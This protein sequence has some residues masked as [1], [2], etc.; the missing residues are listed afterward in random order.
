MDQDNANERE[1]TSP[2]P[3]ESWTDAEARLA[4]AQRGEKTPL[5][6]D[7]LLHEI[8]VHQIE[9]PNET[10]RQAQAAMEESG[11]RYVDLYDFAPVGYLTLSAEGLIT[12]V[13]LTGAA[14]L[15]DDREML[16]N[17]RFADFVVAADSERW[18]GQFRHVLKQG[19]KHVVELSL[20]HADGTAFPARLDCLQRK[21]GGPLV[22]RIA[23]WD[24]TE[25]KRA[26]QA[27][28]DSKILLQSVIDATP[29]WIYVKDSEHRF[30]LVNG[31]FAKAFSRAPADMIG[32]HDTDFMPRQLCEGNPDDGTPGLHDSDSAVFAGQSLHVPCEVIPLEEGETRIFDT[33]KGPLRDTSQRIYGSLCYRRDITERFNKAQE[34]KALELQL[35]QAQKMELVGQLTGG[36]AHDFNNILASILGYAELVQMSPDIQQNSRLTQYLREILQAG[37]RAKEL[38]T[39]LLTFSGRREVPTEAINVA[40]IVKEVAKLLRSTLPTSIS[41]KTDI[42]RNLPQ[43]LMSP[44]QLHQVLMNLGINARDAIT[45]KGA[46]EVKAK[47]VALEGSMACDSCH[48]DFAGSHLVLS[49]RDTGSGIP[50]ENR[51]KIFHPFFTT[52]GVGLGSGLGLSVLHGIVHSANGH[53]KV[54]TALGEGTEFHVYLPPQS[55]DVAPFSREVKPAAGQIPVGRHVMLIDD[56][57]SI[58]GFMTPLLEN[59][60]C[61]VTGLTS[62]TVALRVFQ[63]DPNCVDM[64]I[65]DQTMPDLTGADLARAMLA[66]RR[67]IPVVVSTGYSDEIDENRAREIGIRRLLLK[68]VPAKVLADVVAECLAVKEE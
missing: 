31:P 68:P 13:N 22:V 26:N 12:E 33:F 25:S 53:V 18:H 50:L 2:P 62:S 64:V 58:I 35:W 17:R 61:K 51:S 45:G 15:G 4:R 8:Q 32:R 27:L 54:A 46:I 11:D 48:Q 55:E 30:M 3:P 10:L 1:M 28:R 42:A 14:L 63:A 38:V 44:V 65:T 24:L 52:K 21:A 23:L 20:R 43:V 9:M 60:G 49:V 6:A 37:F 19:G 67:D 66:C 59:L 5:T 47:A 7:E 29:D 34:Q 56:D 16:L 36:I 57:A 39:Q 41:I 40:P